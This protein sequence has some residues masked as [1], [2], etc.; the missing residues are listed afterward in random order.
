MQPHLYPD[1]RA[2]VAFIISRLDGKALRW[3]EPLWTQ[4]H[5]AVTSL[6]SFLEHFREVFGTPA[7]DSSIGERLCRLRQGS[8]TVSDYALQFRTLAA[9]SGWNEQALITTYRQGLDPRIRLHLAAYEDSIGLEKFIQLSIRFAT[10]MQ[11]CLEEHQAQPLFPAA[12]RRPEPVSRP[13]PANEPMDLEHSDLAATERQREWQRRL[14]QNRCFYCGPRALLDSGSAGNFISSALCRQ[15]RLKLT[16]TP[17]VYQVHA[18]TGRPLQTVCHLAG[19]LHL[20]VGALHS[21]EIY[22]LVLEDS[23]ADIVLGR[24]RLEQH[25]PILSWKTGEILKW[26]EQCFGACFPNLPVPVPPRFH[27]VPV[28]ATSVESPTE[29]CTPDIPACYSHFQDVFCPRKASKLPPHRP[30]DCAI[31]LIPGEPVPKGQIYSLSIPEERAMEEYIQEALS[32][33]YRALNQI[34]VKFRYPLP[35]I[36]SV[37]ERLRGVT[38][39]TKLDLHSAYNL[40]RIREGD[41]WKTAFVTPTGHYEYLVMCYGLANTL[42]VFQDFMHTVLREFLHKSVL[43]YIDD[44]LIYSRDYRLFLKAEKCAFHQP[45]VHF[46]GYVIDRNGIRMDEGKVAAVR[47]W[48]VPTSI[49]EL[50]RFLGFANF[51]WRLMRGYSSL[52][53]PLTNLLRNKPKSLTWNPT[54]MQAFD[55]LKTAFT[56]TPLLVHPNLKLPFVVEVNAA[57]TG[58]GAV[59]SQQQRSH[60]TLH[61]CAFFSWKLSPAEVNYDIGNR[62]LLAIKL[63]LEEWKHWLEGAKHPF[64]VLT[65]HK[66]LEYLLAAKGLNPRQA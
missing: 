60:R 21:E 10:R 51:Y 9:A 23:T 62:E 58:V 18:V 30:W 22:L 55:A 53:S 37:L 27:E 17:K 34:T 47:D 7:G 24:P 26:G 1:D 64:V 44:I 11:L 4:N 33:D 8:M 61:L 42:S 50:Q 39:F 40:I 3:V 36:P 29:T 12:P 6:S 57:T 56:T 25:D 38:V 65:D 32:Q 63:A 54:A 52:T 20:Q 13:E 43:V 5:P 28:H 35:L 31:D 49:K 2:K 41:E 19:P 14:A 59:L 66:K 45:S 16:A 46:L 15:L 48:P